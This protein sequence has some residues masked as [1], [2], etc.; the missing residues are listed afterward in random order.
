MYAAEK[1]CSGTAGDHTRRSLDCSH[2]ASRPTT[3][4]RALIKNGV[5]GGGAD[6]TVAACSLSQAYA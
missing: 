2:V 5:E 4:V 1:T 6:F 3:K